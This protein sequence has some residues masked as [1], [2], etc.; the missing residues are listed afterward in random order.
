MSTLNLTL[1]DDLLAQ[2]QDYAQRTGTDL[3]VLVAELLRPVVTAAPLQRQPTLED[4][5]ALAGCI[6][7]PP[8]FDYKAV[9]GDHLWEK[10]MGLE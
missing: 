3:S 4:V 2:A 6:S 5:N 7:L 1:D 8:N 9:Y 10:Y